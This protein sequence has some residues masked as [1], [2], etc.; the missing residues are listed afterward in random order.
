MKY[1]ITKINLKNKNYP[2]QKKIT[3]KDP[4]KKNTNHNIF[5]GKLKN[6]INNIVNWGRKNSLWPFNFGL[7]CCYVEMVTAF[8]SVHDVSR[9]G[10][11][12]L[13][14]SPRQADVMIIAG[15]PFIKMAPII[16]RLYDQM[17]EPKWVIS[18]GACA[19]SGGMYDIYSV[20]QGVDK[21]LP[22]DVYIPG[23]PPRPEA[24]IQ[25]L[26]L[27]QDSIA[28]E[29]RPLSWIIGD[30]GVYKAKMPSEK[31]KKQKKIINIKHID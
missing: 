1:T 17:L 22:V 27:L 20:V 8:T 7:S 3:I 4:L 14:A 29:R 21:F 11:E 24:Y 9:F 23:C 15:T 2:I 6:I 28:K 31:N 10:S 5:M 12:V 25:A 26:M 16:Q 19:N 18:M 30:Q 13:R